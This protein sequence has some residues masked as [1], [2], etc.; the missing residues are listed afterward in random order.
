[1]R[2]GFFVPGFPKAGTS[3]LCRWLAA[4]PQVK[5]PVIKE[6]HFFSK[7]LGNDRVPTLTRYEALF[8]STAS[9]H[10]LAGEGSTNY[11]YSEEAVSRIMDYN[12]DA[13]FIVCLRNPIDLL[14]SLYQE[15]RCHCAEPAPTFEAAWSSRG[16]HDSMVGRR[17]LTADHL[18]NYRVAGMLGHHCR[19]LL[20]VVPRAQVFFVLLDDMK[21]DPASVFHGVLDFLGL[22]WYAAVDLEKCNS[23]KRLRSPLLRGLQLAAGQLKR[24]LG[25]DRNFGLLRPLYSVVYAPMISPPLPYRLRCE[26]AGAFREDIGLLAD[27]TGRDLTLWL[28]L[29]TN[30]R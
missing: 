24:R 19:R 10:Q 16:A 27:L 3:S 21:S 14:P 5:F 18:I 9:R 30:E 25:I 15:Y 11:L 4:H 17:F 23:A 20:T 7:D 22:V 28:R 2:P 13:R 8:A 12:A 26:L 6:P 1:M 29:Q